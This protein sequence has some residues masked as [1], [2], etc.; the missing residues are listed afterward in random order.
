[1]KKKR[2]KLKEIKNQLKKKTLYE[3]HKKIEKTRA[4]LGKKI[5]GLLFKKKKKII[6]QQ[7]EKER[8]RRN[9]KEEFV[10]LLLLLNH[11]FSKRKEM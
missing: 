11:F 6:E 10:N 5:E 8:K 2:K 1:M 4:T 7:Q 3:N 9:R